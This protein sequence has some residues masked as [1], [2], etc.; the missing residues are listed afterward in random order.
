MPLPKSFV[1]KRVPISKIKLDKIEE[2][3][4]TISDA[5]VAYLDI[6]GFSGKTNEKDIEATLYDFSG[7]LTLVVHTYPK[8]RINLFS[9]CAFIAT[10]KENARDLLSSIRFAFKEWVADGILVRGGLTMGRYVEYKRHS[11]DMT[12]PN[13]IGNLFFGS[14]VNAAVRLEDSG[15]AALLFADEECAKFYHKKFGEPIYLLDDKNVIGWSDDPNV[16]YWFIGISFIQ[17]LR[18]LDSK[19]GEKHPVTEILMNNIRYSFRI[20]PDL[21]R[22]LVLAILSSSIITSSVRNKACKLLKIDLHKYSLPIKDL[23]NEWLKTDKLEWLVGIA[24]MDS[25]IPSSL[26][27]RNSKLK[28]S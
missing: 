9:D 13:F 6:L 12:P 16:L 26:R 17:L 8:V 23:I 18:L 15:S 20:N 25:S 11:I 10:P 27:R 14:A 22:F 24:E 1:T 5:I 3:S 2:K 28:K 4:I 7:P 21:A 19:D